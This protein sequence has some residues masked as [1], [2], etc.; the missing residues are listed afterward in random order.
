VIGGAGGAI[1]A[2]DRDEYLDLPPGTRVT[3][4][5]RASRDRRPSYGCRDRHHAGE[6]CIAG[7]RLSGRLYRVIGCQKVLLGFLAAG[8][9]VD[10]SAACLGLVFIARRG[11]GQ[12][13][14]A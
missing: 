10:A 2:Q 3:V 9:I 12:A 13:R 7:C 11:F 6:T 8:S 4:I 1:L 5:V 14:N